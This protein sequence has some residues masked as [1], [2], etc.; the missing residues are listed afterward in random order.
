MIKSYGDVV[1]PFSFIKIVC[2]ENSVYW[3]TVTVSYGMM[4]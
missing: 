4:M 3:T 1:T 2:F